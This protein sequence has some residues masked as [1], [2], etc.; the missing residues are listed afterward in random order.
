MISARCF[1]RRSGAPSVSNERNQSP[2]G[3]AGAAPDAGQCPQADHRLLQQPARSAHRRTARELRHL[4]T[5][6]QSVS[7]WLQRMAR[8]GDQPGH[9]RVPQAAGHRR[10]AVSRASTRMRCPSRR[11]PARS[12]CWRRT[13]SRSCSRR[14]TNT[15]RR[16]RFRTRS[17]PTTA[18]GNRGLADG[19]VIT[20]SHNPPDDGGFK[21]NPPNGGPADTDVTGWIQAR[22]NELLAGSLR[23]VKRMPLDA[24]A[25][26][27]DD[28][29][30]RF[31][32]QPMSPISAMSSTWTS[33]AAPAS[34][35]ASIRWAAPA[36]TTGR[37]S[38]S[39]IGSNLTVVN[40]EVDPTFRFMTRGLGRQDPHGSVLALCDAA[41]DRPEGSL[42]HRLRLRHRS[43]PAWH[44]HPQR[45]TAAAES[46]SVGGDRL[47]VPAPAALAPP[48]RRS[49]R[50][51]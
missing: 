10:A 11:S 42:R 50:R 31:P 16:R 25:A 6:R 48:M 46:L 33:S 40:D 5:S 18:G 47:P 39:A 51:W 21:Y 23:G 8:A 12:R 45:R 28:P 19:I 41:A 30:P 44:R 32:R 24:G 43:R 14:T 35:W 4:R 13:A 20:P 9:L 26:Q 1:S 15:R 36:C 17:S 29:S 2:G 49:A 34:A 37:R 22:A 7:Q 38:P 3:Q 27:P